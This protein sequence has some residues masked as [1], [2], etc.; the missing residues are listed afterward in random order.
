VTTDLASGPP[1]EVPAEIEVA[2]ER[3]RELFATAMRLHFMVGRRGLWAERRPAGG[4]RS[5][6]A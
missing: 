5:S 6:G 3:A 2:W 4:D 1:P